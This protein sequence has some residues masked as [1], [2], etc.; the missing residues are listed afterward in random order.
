MKRKLT[1]F[2]SLVLLLVLVCTAA[3]ARTPKEVNQLCGLAEGLGSLIGSIADGVPVS[4][5]YFEEID[6]VALGATME[7]VSTSDLRKRYDEDE[8]FKNQSIDTLT[9]LYNSICAVLEGSGYSD[10]SV[11]VMFCGDDGTDAISLVDGF[12]VT[13]YMD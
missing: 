8:D 7:G 6:T 5:F 13:P 9:A 4:C 11:I 10:V 3:F 12:D 2:V 1:V